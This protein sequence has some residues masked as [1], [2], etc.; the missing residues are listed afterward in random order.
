LKRTSAAWNI[1]QAFGG[2]AQLGKSLPEA[3]ARLR[4]L[5]GDHRHG[6]DAALAA[7][8]RRRALGGD[9]GHGIAAAAAAHFQPGVEMGQHATHPDHVLVRGAGIDHDAVALGAEVIHDQVVDHA[10]GL[11]EHAGIQRLA[12]HGE[13]GHVVGQQ[14]AQVVARLRPGEVERAHVR[15]VE[16]AGVA[17]HDMVFLDLRAVVDGHFPAGEIDHLGAGGEMGVV[18]RGA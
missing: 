9:D 18:E 17:A 10:A 12:G 1:G 16:H 8:V 13:L 6:V 3:L 14:V 5:H 2:G 11:V 7:F 15:D 4:A